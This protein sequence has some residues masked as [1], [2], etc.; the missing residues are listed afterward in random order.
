MTISEINLEIWAYYEIKKEKRKEN[1]ELAFYTAYFG[2]VERLEGK[3]LIDVLDKI[4][5]PSNEM[6]D[7]IMLRNFE[8]FAAGFG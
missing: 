2:R 7:E 4:D 8:R 5:N 6:S 3:N 1:M